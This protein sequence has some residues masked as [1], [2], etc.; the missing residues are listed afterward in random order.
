MPRWPTRTTEERFAE[1]VDR[2]DG[3][4]QWTGSR[5]NSGY[6]SFFHDG[7]GRPAHRVA[8]EIYVGSI[9]DGLTIDHLCRNKL[10]VRPDHLEPVSLSTNVRRVHGSE[11]HCRRGHPRTPE[12]ACTRKDEIYSCRLCQRIARQAWEARQR[13]AA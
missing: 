7:S 12:N 8:Y 3:C 2:S 10:C 1:K 5:L 4:W 13:E 11:T 9:P 6:G